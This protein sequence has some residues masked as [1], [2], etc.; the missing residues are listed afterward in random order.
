M[1]KKPHQTEEQAR[2]EKIKE[3]KKAGINP[4]PTWNE[5]RQEIRYFLDNF[6]TLDEDSPITLAGRITSIRPQGG[7]IFAHIKDVTGEVQLFFK[8]NN[9]GDDQYKLVKQLDR[10]DILAAHGTPFIT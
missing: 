2:I 7:T 9:L 10:A 1:T 6:E 8:K 3:L 4:F 5:E